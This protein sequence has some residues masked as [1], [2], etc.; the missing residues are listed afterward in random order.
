MCVRLDI[1]KTGS[2]ANIGVVVLSWLTTERLDLGPK[3][4][5]PYNENIF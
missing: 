2:T 4:L 3:A 5:I 1:T